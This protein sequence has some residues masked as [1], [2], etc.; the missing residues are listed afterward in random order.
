MRNVLTLTNISAANQ[1]V[2]VFRYVDVDLAG[3]SSGDS[4]TSIG[5]GNNH[6]RISDGVSTL[7][8]VGTNTAYRLT[9]YN[10]LRAALN[11]AAIDNFANTDRKSTRLNSSH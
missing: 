10:T 6:V 5:G 7:D 4:A 1:A 2:T 3:T 8:V 9:T 11:D